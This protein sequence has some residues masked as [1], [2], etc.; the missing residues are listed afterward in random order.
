MDARGLRTSGS[1]TFPSTLH[2]I[3]SCNLDSHEDLRKRDKRFRAIYSFLQV[4]RFAFSITNKPICGHNAPAFEK[5]IRTR[6]W[7][8]KKEIVKTC[9]NVSEISDDFNDL[10]LLRE[11]VAVM[12]G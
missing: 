1:K 7:I 4:Q 8:T 12:I 9:F 6:A 2:T 10:L 3:F 11:R 5:H